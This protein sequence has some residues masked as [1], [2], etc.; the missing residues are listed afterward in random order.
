MYIS[1]SRAL[2]AAMVRKTNLISHLVTTES[3]D[4]G[5]T[6]GHN[7]PCFTNSLVYDWGKQREKFINYNSC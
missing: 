1:P 7:C 6:F 5:A 3:C 4:C 2:R